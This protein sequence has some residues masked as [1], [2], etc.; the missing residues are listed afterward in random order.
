[1]KKGVKI[2]ELDKE[3]MGCFYVGQVV[4]GL[5]NGFGRKVNSRNKYWEGEFDNGI[6]RKGKFYNFGT[7]Q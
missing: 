4:D 1:M 2:L 5:P 3:N 7:T 6:F